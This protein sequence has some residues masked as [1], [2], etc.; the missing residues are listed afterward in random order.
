M[1]VNQNILM[2]MF[3][4]GALIGR[5]RFT[6]EAYLAFKKT[7]MFICTMMNVLSIGIYL[8]QRRVNYRKLN[9]IMVIQYKK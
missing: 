8:A 7:V 6:R 5:V 2:P 9:K 1:F 4:L 3:S